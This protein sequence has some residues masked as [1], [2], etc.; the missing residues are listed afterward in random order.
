MP[1]TKYI[2]WSCVSPYV[3]LI[4]KPAHAFEPTTILNTTQLYNHSILD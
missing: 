2:V 1:D 4:L 3:A